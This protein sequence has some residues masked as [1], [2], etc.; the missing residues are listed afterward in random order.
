MT[1][2]LVL[3]HGVFDFLHWGHLMHLQEARAMGTILV[4]T[5]TA[6][7][8]VSKGHGR[9]IFTE[10]QRAQMLRALAIVD[11]VDIVYDKSAIPAI[12]KYRPDL[13]VKGSDYNN[14]KGREKLEAE[15]KAVKSYGGRLVFTE[16]ISGF[17]TT[18]LLRKVY[19]ALASQS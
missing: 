7:N 10:Y 17:S 15:E 14:A 6:D 13:Y 19:H 12:M 16:N 1:K 4:V 5:I 9:P 11:E 2:K 3:C 18:T 8:Y